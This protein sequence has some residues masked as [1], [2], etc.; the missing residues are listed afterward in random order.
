MRGSENAVDKGDSIG[1]FRDV[2]RDVVVL[3]RGGVDPKEPV[4][5]LLS[6]DFALNI[7]LSSYCCHCISEM[8]GMLSNHVAS[9]G[10]HLRICS[11]AEK[12]TR[13]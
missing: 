2:L 13:T 1:T 9:I 4:A 12:H 11:V 10:D 7:I 6:R 5:V 8:K 3:D